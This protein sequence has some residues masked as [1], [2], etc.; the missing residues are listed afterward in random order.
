MPITRSHTHSVELAAPPAVVFPWLVTPSA[1]CQW[2]HADRALVVAEPGGYWMAAWGSDVDSPEY[3]TAARLDIYEPPH[4]LRLGDTRYVAKAG[5]LP[6]RM[7]TTIE[8]RVEPLGDGSRLTV[9]QHGFP[10]EAVAEEFYQACV[11]GW[12]D[13]LAS[14]AAFASGATPPAAR[15]AG[16]AE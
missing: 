7:D 14:F 9:V 11:T 1:I 10:T 8:F 6:F 2:W 3:C 12:R 4:R 16:E 15:S 13:T 5:P